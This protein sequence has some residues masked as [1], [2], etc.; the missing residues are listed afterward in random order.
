M[1][2]CTRALSCCPRSESDGACVFSLFTR[3][4]HCVHHF[5][6]WQRCTH[7][8]HSWF[9]MRLWGLS[10]SFCIYRARPITFLPLAPSRKEYIVRVLCVCASAYLYFLAPT[11]S[12]LVQSRFSLFHTLNSALYANERTLFAPSPSSS[13]WYSVRDQIVL[14]T[15]RA[16][17]ARQIAAAADNFA[18]FITPDLQVERGWKRQLACSS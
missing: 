18:D 7:G 13:G 2:I 6:L 10:F 17:C 15:L 5:S 12:T 1:L 9:Y 4:S 11:H 16:P 8:V 3:T 14:N